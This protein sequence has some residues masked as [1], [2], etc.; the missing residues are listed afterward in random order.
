M[1]DSVY[2]TGS[3]ANFG[4]CGFISRAGSHVTNGIRFGATVRIGLP[5]VENSTG[6][7]S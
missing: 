3:V 4:Y 2:E 1:L 6:K 7:F 5:L